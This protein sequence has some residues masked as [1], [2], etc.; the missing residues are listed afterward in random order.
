MNLTIPIDIVDFI[1]TDDSLKIV[2]IHFKWSSFIPNN[3]D[4]KCSNVL[5]I[6]GSVHHKK[7]VVSSACHVLFEGNTLIVG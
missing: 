2:H 7:V 3:I 1:E 5:S 4:K 6:D